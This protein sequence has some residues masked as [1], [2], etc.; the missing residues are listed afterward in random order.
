MKKTSD[1]TPVKRIEVK[2]IMGVIF[3]VIGRQ[4]DKSLRRYP[5]KA[6]F[7]DLHAGDGGEPTSPSSCLSALGILRDQR[8][9]KYLPFAMHLYEKHKKRRVRLKEYLEVEHYYEEPNGSR[10]ELHP[11]DNIDVLNLRLF[12]NGMGLVYADPY[13]G[14]DFVNIFIELSK[15]VEYKRIDFLVNISCASVKRVEGGLAKC[16]GCIHGNR[17][18]ECLRKI[19][20]E[21]LKVH[22]PTGGWQWTLALFT[23]APENIFDRTGFAKHDWYS[24]AES[25]E[26]INQV[27][28]TR[29]EK[30]E[31]R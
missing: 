15:K 7:I 17:L 4:Y 29:K 20:K 22:K 9:K 3:G 30:E 6:V 25:W 28:L 27:A 24:S 26:V 21:T 10:V 13:G 31:T 12:K 1:W 8:E 23:N 18:S 14:C 5:Y 19:N 11:I 2:R 16:S